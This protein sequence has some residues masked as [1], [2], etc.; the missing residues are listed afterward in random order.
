MGLTCAEEKL[1]IVKE[2]IVKDQVPQE[3][4]DNK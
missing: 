4:K 1:D 3:N 2:Y